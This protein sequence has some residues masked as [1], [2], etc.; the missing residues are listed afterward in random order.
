MSNP[1][2]SYA[3]GGCAM[4][5][6]GWFILGFVVLVMNGETEVARGLAAFIAGMFLTA[7]GVAGGKSTEY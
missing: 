1:R 6:A 5:V 7:G 2:D 4:N 3:V